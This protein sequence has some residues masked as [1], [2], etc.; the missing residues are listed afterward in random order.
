M[1]LISMM[2]SII[3]QILMIFLNNLDNVQLL[4]D[5]FFLLSSTN[6]YFTFKRMTKQQKVSA[7]C[8]KLV[9]FKHTEINFDY[10]S[11]YYR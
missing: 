2:L 4:P 10:K 6:A 8:F 11:V 5:S 9:T 7:N 3:F 1:L